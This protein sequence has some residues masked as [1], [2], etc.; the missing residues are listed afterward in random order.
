MSLTILTLGLLLIKLSVVGICASNQLVADRGNDVKAS[1]SIASNGFLLLMIY[2]K[3]TFFMFAVFLFC[4]VWFTL[5]NSGP[6]VWMENTYFQKADAAVLSENFKSVPID[7]LSDNIRLVLVILGIF[8]GL[9]TFLLFT[10]MQLMKKLV[11]RME[12]I[13]SLIQVQ[14]TSLAVM[15]LVF[16]IV[17]N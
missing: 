1:R 11:R 8:C 7:A 16:L 13:S 3:L 6:A 5:F 15:A 12:R 17:V 2:M 14:S 4:T 9:I 10:S